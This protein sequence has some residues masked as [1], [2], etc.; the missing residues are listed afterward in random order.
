MSGFENTNDDIFAQLTAGL[1]VDEYLEEREEL[2]AKA[3]ALRAEA[4]ALDA[5]AAKLGSTVE[6]RDVKIAPEHFERTVDG[7]L[8]LAPDTEREKM[9]LMLAELR[10]EAHKAGIVRRQMEDMTPENLFEEIGSEVPEEMPNEMLEML[11]D[12]MTQAFAMQAKMIDLTPGITTVDV[13]AES[14]EKVQ[15]T[16]QEALA[17][18]T[19]FGGMLGKIEMLLDVVEGDMSDEELEQP[20]KDAEE[21]TALVAKLDA[22]LV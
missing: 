12:G 5:R 21:L 22:I 13:V 7:I 11:K 20:R 19:L 2:R 1:E 3:A 18:R 6:E 8:F 17:W 14:L 15:I 16:S 10:A 4:D 9:R